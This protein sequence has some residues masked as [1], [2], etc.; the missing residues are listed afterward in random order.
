MKMMKNILQHKLFILSDYSTYSSGNTVFNCL[1]FRHTK[2]LYKGKKEQKR[3]FIKMKKPT[4]S[5]QLPNVS[6]AKLT[7]IN[8]IKMKCEEYGKE[9]NI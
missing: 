6:I 2:N 8:H 7:F 4:K 1:R 9:K 5:V 3:I